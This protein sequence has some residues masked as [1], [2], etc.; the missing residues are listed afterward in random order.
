[1]GLMDEGMTYSLHALLYADELAGLLRRMWRGVRIDD[2]MLAME[3]TR[4]EGPR[5]N[6]LAQPHTSEHCRTEA[7]TPRYLGANQPVSTSPLPDIDLYERVDADL[8]EILANHQPKPLPESIL[9]E[10]RSIQRAF[11]ES[12]GK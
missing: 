2:E 1:M 7:W 9:S 5:G 6:Y 12:H 10:I 8:R 3:L 4:K 11:E